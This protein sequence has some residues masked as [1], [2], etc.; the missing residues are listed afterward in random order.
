VG[1]AV[2]TKTGLARSLMNTGGRCA[3]TIVSTS[4]CDFPRI[5]ERRILWFDSFK[6][7]ATRE[8]VIRLT[9]FFSRSP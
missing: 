7:D 9:S 3:A 1:F 4:R 2:A 6:I 5:S 8:I